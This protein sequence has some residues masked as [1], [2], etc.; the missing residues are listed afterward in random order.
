MLRPLTI[1][2]AAAG[3]ISAA[4]MTYTF[5][6]TGTGVW[7]ST[8]FSDATFTFTF[9]ADTTTVIHG[10]SCCGNTDS[11]PSGT[12]A[13]VSVSGF[14]PAQLTGDQAIFID[15]A[16]V[17][18]GIWH[19]NAAQ[20]ATVTNSVFSTDDLTSTIPPST[21]TGTAWSYATPFTL[22][23]GGTLYFSSVQ[24]VYYSQ[25]PGSSGGQITA[26]S[27]TP[28]SGT[29]QEFTT[30][31]YT[32]VVSDTSGA[33]DIGGVDLQFRDKPN[34]PNACWLY[35]NAGTN[36]LDVNRSNTWSTPGAVGSGGSILNGDACTVDTNAVTVSNSGNDL[37]LA[38]PIQLSY[39]DNN[40]WPIFVAAQSKENIDTDYSQ[41]GT[42]TAETPQQSG[43]FS[44]SISPNNGVYA[45]P[46]STVTYTLTM[47][48]QNGF[49]EPVTFSASTETATKSDTTQLSYSF[50][51]ATLTTSGTSTMTVSFPDS[52]TPDEYFIKVTGS[53][54]S[55]SQSVSGDI[56]LQNGPPSGTLSPTTGTGSSQTFT[57]DFFENPWSHPTFLNMLIASS[58][59]GRNACWISFDNSGD[60]GPGDS[61]AGQIFLASDDGTSWVSAGVANRLGGPGSGSA[62][63]SQCT[64][65][66]G[67]I[68][69]YNSPGL[70]IPVTFTSTFAGPK[71]IYV[72]AVDGA[73]YETGYQPMGAWSI[74]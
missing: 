34:Q 7:N 16:N 56:L 67:A 61:G 63:N 10:T 22:N 33:S 74:Q 23:T 38:I 2:I 66:P 40:T 31:T 27:V 58:L 30:Q 21:V 64:I 15:H 26:V 71:T 8:P 55:V 59:D 50:N 13:T 18:A 37:T 62:S 52:A 65:G 48:D 45:R 69:G 19:F 29:Q 3:L 49:S 11:T 4:P 70:H 28:S 60:F 39:A 51:P 72:Y 17:T 42:V 47:T 54:Q 36:T 5:T 25:Q 73:G 9:N 32:F 1:L 20:Y 6:G 46:G 57:L 41:L 43:T 53:S 35:Y 14:S 68:L 44:L 12:T 24:G